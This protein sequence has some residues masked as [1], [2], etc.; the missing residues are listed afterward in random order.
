MFNN[1]YIYIYIY[2]TYLRSFKPFNFIR[3]PKHFFF[4]INVDLLF[5]LQNS[6]LLNLAIVL[7]GLHAM[8]TRGVGWGACSLIWPIRGCAAGQTTIREQNLDTLDTN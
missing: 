5:D 7:G 8:V 4:L 2:T 6:V 1:N 3:G